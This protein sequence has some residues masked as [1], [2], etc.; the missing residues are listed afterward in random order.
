MSLVRIINMVNGGKLLINLTRVSTIELKDKNLILNMSTKNYKEN[1][2][3]LECDTRENANIE[4]K[5]IS[6]AL[7]KYYKD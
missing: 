6:M 2:V 3:T 5:N 4:L 1:T 7:N